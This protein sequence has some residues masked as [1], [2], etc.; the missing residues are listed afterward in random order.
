MSVKLSKYS[1]PLL[2]LS[3]LLLAFGC[4]SMNTTTFYV[5]QASSKGEASATVPSQYREAVEQIMVS[6]AAEAGFEEKPPRWPVPQMIRNFEGPAGGPSDL[7]LVAQV[8]DDAIVVSLTEFRPGIGET[9]LYRKTKDL[10]LSRLKQRFGDQVTI[11]KPMKG[12]NA[13]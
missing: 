9:G 10:L 5:T 12:D 4:D 11:C 7:N 6:V 8:A 13:P 3:L 2:R 1:Q